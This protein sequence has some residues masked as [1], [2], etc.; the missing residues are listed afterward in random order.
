MYLEDRI[1][2]LKQAI[3]CYDFAYNATGNYGY[4]ISRDNALLILW[5]ELRAYNEINGYKIAA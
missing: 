1:D 3:R 5:R 4:I 2:I